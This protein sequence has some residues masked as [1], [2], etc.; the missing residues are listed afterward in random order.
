MHASCNGGT[1]LAWLEL[2]LHTF[3]C[4]NWLLPTMHNLS[5]QRGRGSNGLSI[6]KPF[7]HGLIVRK[8]T[9]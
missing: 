8:A 7:D 5:T 2:W 4:F 9:Q 3:V 1:T 6:E